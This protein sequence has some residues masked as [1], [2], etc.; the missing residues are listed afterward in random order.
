MHLKARVE[1]RILEQCHSQ[2]VGR[3]RVKIFCPLFVF[4]SRKKNW[5]TFRTPMSLNNR[6][7]CFI[8]FYFYFLLLPEQLN[9]VV[10]RW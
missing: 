5:V 7:P 9:F 8:F 6:F 2:T 1:K 4:L 3:E 10:S